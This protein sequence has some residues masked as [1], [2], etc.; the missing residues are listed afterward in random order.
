MDAAGQNLTL[1]PLRGIK[2]PHANTYIQIK[3]TE[4]TSFAS[5]RYV[6]STRH[7]LYSSHTY[8]G[9]YIIFLHITVPEEKCLLCRASDVTAILGRDSCEQ[10]LLTPRAHKSIADAQEVIADVACG[11]LI[12]SRRRI[13]KLLDCPDAQVTL[14]Y[15]QIYL[16]ERMDVVGSSWS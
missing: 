6:M 11:N 15:R 2:L 1:E 4:R 8:T 12:I 14:S 3:R 9:K 7:R 13:V 10:S 5:V 16:P